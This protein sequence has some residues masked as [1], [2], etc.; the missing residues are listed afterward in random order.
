M[1]K[2]KVYFF[3]NN[4]FPEMILIV[5]LIGAGLVAF[6]EFIIYLSLTIL[7]INKEGADV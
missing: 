7:F 6:I 1:I 3:I 4:I 5:L 2:I